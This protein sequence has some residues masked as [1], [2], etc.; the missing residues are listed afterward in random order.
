[1]ST[2]VGAGGLMVWLKRTRWSLG[3]ARAV[4]MANVRTSARA[5]EPENAWRSDRSM[6]RPSRSGCAPPRERGPAP[7]LCRRSDLRASH[8]GSSSVAAPHALPAAWPSVPLSNNVASG[9]SPF[10]NRSGDVSQLPAWWPRGWVVNRRWGGLG[11]GSLVWTRLHR[12][13]DWVGCI[14]VWQEQQRP[15]LTGSGR[16]SRPDLTTTSFTHSCR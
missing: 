5:T 13:F 9:K 15:W 3:A 2:L 1:M 14:A 12:R 10:L 11:S 8:R 6:G 7:A 16:T 4:L